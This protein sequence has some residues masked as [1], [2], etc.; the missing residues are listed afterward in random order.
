MFN[1]LFTIDNLFDA[2]KKFKRG[3]TKKRDVVEF[4]YHLED[5]IFALHRDNINFTYIH[6]PYTYFQV[7]DTKKRDIYKAYVEDRVVHQ[8]MYTYL[9]NLYEPI[10]ISD[11]YSSRINK[12]SIHAVNTFRYFIKM[13]SQDKSKNCWV[14]KCDIRKYFENI[15]HDILYKELHL[16]IID[17]KVLFIIDSII[18]SYASQGDSSKGIPLGNVTSQ[19]FANIYLHKLDMY[20]KKDLKCNWYIRY[21]DDF[22]IIGK[23]REKLVLIRDKIMLFI[24]QELRLDIPIEKTSIRKALW[25]IDFLGYRIL[26]KG[27]LLRNNTK[28]KIYTNITEYNKSS[29]FALL[30]WCNSYTLKQK[31]LSKIKENSEE[32]F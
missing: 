9:T 25:G 16:K 3:K 15:N 1:E 17:E 28:Q 5:N 10:F 14:L 26:E 19:I 13:C 8:V 7:F 4:E 18:R 24:K 11:S 29:Y 30:K 27:I 20:I 22:V 6:K 2:W 31:L 21:N 23:N 32:I 12:G